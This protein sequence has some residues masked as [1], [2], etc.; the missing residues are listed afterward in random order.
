MTTL[1]LVTGQPNAPQDGEA[2]FTSEILRNAVLHWI[3]IDGQIYTGIFPQPDYL[4]DPINGKVTRGNDNK[5]KLGEKCIFVY[6]K[7]NC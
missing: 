1:Q 3:I 7:C 6:S 4:F 5:F 2:E